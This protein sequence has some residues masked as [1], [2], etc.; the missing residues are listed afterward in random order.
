MKDVTPLTFR[1]NVVYCLNGSCDKTQPYIGKTER[2]LVAR[3][4]EHLSGKSGKPA[5]H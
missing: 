4:Q 5:I 2:H 3:V 1:A